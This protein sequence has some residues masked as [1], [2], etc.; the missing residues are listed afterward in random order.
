MQEGID[1]ESQ[2]S[3]SSV[4][5]E[6]SV[7]VVLSSS[8]EKNPA[9]SSSAGVVGTEAT[10]PD[11]TSDA[12]AGTSFAQFA[13][14]STIVLSS[15]PLSRGLESNNPAGMP[16]PTW[17]RQLQDLPE[18]IYALSVVPGVLYVWQGVLVIKYWSLRRKKTLAL[19]LVFAAL[20][21]SFLI[22]G[23][24]GSVF[25]DTLSAMQ[26]CY[27]GCLVFG[28]LSTCGFGSLAV[29]CIRSRQPD[30][31][32]MKFTPVSAARHLGKSDHLINLVSVCLFVCFFHQFCCKLAVASKSCFRCRRLTAADEPGLMQAQ[33]LSGERVLRVLLC[34]ACFGAYIEGGREGGGGG[35]G[36][37][38]TEPSCAIC[39]DELGERIACCSCENGHLFHY[40]CVEQWVEHA[41][42]RSC[43]VCRG[44]I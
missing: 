40:A 36:G 25:R 16:A 17:L 42:Q 14:G 34:S 12:A 29:V 44:A 4:P 37:A 2:F 11:A 35:E 33:L 26:L 9:D 5:L 24:F 10:Q 30:E 1:L 39:L 28:I 23:I 7:V 3:S 43:P 22:C 31:L 19:R 8:P 15:L 38:S 18:D 13:P 27:F 21:V 6:Q 41:P 20:S 32:S